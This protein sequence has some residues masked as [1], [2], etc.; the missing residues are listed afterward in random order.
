MAK[1]RKRGQQE[2]FGGSW[3]QEKL[4]RVQKYLFAYCQIFKP[5]A[6]GGYFET[7]YVDAFA[8]TGYMRKPDMPLAQFFPEEFAEL[9]REAEEYTKGSA[10][11]ALEVEPG[12]K[13]YIF[14]E[15]I[16]NRSPA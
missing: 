15:Q 9:S 16:S 3:T 5:G 8:G 7:A 13:R 11:R 2:L 14:I 1:R 10:V 6:K 12:F 4:E